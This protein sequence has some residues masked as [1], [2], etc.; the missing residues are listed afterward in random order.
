MVWK[1]SSWS[2][3]DDAGR[4]PNIIV[5]MRVDNGAWVVIGNGPFN[6]HNGRML[7]GVTAIPDGAVVLD[8][9][10]TPDPSEV[11]EGTQVVGAGDQV[12]LDVPPFEQYYSGVP[13]TPMPTATPV[14]PMPTVVPPTPTSTPTAI[15][16]TPTPEEPPPVL[17]PP[18]PTATPT[19]VPPTV[20]PPPETM[21]TAPS[22]SAAV[23]CTDTGIEISVEGAPGDVFDIFVDGAPSTLEVPASGSVT[24]EIAQEPGAT[25]VIEV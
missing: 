20:T 6:E 5:E 24:L 17:P 9:R 15:P 1:T 7:L 8:V 16:P 23:V 4:H 19:E 21:P 3:T 13:P 14:P 12:T 11:W 18:T 22:R 25:A 10:V 2:L